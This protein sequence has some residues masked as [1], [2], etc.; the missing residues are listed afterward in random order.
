M[1]KLTLEFSSPMCYTVRRFRSS[2]TPAENHGSPHNYH[3]PAGVPHIS[4]NNNKP[5]TT[6]LKYFHTKCQVLIQRHVSSTPRSRRGYTTESSFHSTPTIQSSVKKPGQMRRKFL[7]HVHGKIRKL[8]NFRNANHSTKN[9]GMKNESN[10]TEIS[11]TKLPKIKVYLTWLSSF[12]NFLR[13]L[14]HSLV[15]NSENLNRDFSSNERR[16]RLFSVFRC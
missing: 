15:E 2:Y 13:I 11:D 14:S 7:C 12:Q 8:L 9:A 6:R 4:K 10:P 16:P 1:F 5:N 3:Y